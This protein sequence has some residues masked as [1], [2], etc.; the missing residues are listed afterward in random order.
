MSFGRLMSHRLRYAGAACYGLAAAC[1]LAAL[2]CTSDN[3]TAR[4][5]LDPLGIA[6]KPKDQ[7]DQAAFK[8]RVAND[9]FPPANQ[10]GLAAPQK[11]EAK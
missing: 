2:G 7:T 8:K 1:C 4:R 5:W 6:E 10:V 11:T 3:A 9:T